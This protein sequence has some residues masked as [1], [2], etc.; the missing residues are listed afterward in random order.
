MIAFR[1]L[2]I[3]F[4]V[5]TISTQVRG[6]KTFST[7]FGQTIRRDVALPTKAAGNVIKLFRINDKVAAVTTSGVYDYDG[8]QWTSKTPP[9]SF[10]AAAL[11]KQENLW[12]CSLS[13]IRNI[14]RGTEIRLPANIEKDT[15]RCLFWADSQTLFLGTS[16]GLYSWNNAWT[17]IAPLGNTQVNAVTKDAR[18][19]LWVATMNGLWQCKDTKWV[20]LDETVMATGNERKYYALT[21]DHK[22]EKLIFSTPHAI[23]CIAQSGD[24]WVWRNTDGLPYGPSTVI[25]VSGNTTWL[26]TARGAIARDSSWRYY[27][28]Q[29][30]LPDDQVNDILEVA[31]DVIWVATTKGI[32]EIRKEPIT[33]AKKAAIYEEII[34]KRHNRLGIINISKLQ[35]PGDL[36]TNYTENEDN[37]GLW[38]SCYLAAECFR[39]AATKSPEANKL[40]SRTF[41]ALERLETV[42][43][44]SGYPARSYAR[45]SDK[46][47]Q[48]RSPH[49]KSWHPSPD[50]QW[51]WLD[52]TSSDEITGHLFSLS[53][54]YELVADNQQKKR[55]VDLIDR[56]VTHI[57]DHQ[58]H[59]ID[60]D[61]KPT[62]WGVWHPDSLNNSPNWMTERGLNSLQMLSH[63]K[64][65]ARFTGKQKYEDVYK[66]LVREHGYAQNALYAKLYGPFETSHSDDILNFFPY[67]GL[68]K[69]SEG[70]LNHPLFMK[71]LERSWHNV[72]DDHMPAWNV[73]ASALTGR[74]CDLATAKKELED[75]PLDLVD[76][77]VQNSHRWDLVKDPLNDRGNRAQAI[78][79]IP[80]PESGISRWNTNL[81]RMDVGNQ[82]KTE[83]TG[84]YFLF[85]YWMGRYYGF[86]E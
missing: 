46:V 60:F 70:D 51:Q 44:I 18:G 80:T 25:Y 41:E 69:Y 11:D 75:Y 36:S 76:W 39:Y 33:L 28:G 77:S 23:A 74:N 32:S 65:A 19:T 7:T 63:L 71:S 40:A 22:G 73:I 27:A 34:D 86:W 42:T 56:I 29:R 4:I 62:R 37:D 82:G 2:P 43:G 84:T 38:T 66:M 61:G 9:G 13:T 35:T 58:F 14:D 59:L 81:K 79:P 68:L 67:Y 26:G 50:G 72:K 31:P 24:H 1:I 85:S 8:G 3:L 64:T 55:V 12:V 15:I 48:S 45:A 47:K 54:F 17:R 5:V 83:E 6:Q 78:A 49:P 57:I 16:N 21:R 20:N 52:D 10:L 53:L 30:W